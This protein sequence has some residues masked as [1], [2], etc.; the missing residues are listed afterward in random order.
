MIHRDIKPENILI[1]EEDFKAKLCDL[2][3]A[4]SGDDFDSAGRG[5]GTPNYM[6]PEQIRGKN[7]DIR[8]DIYS[9]G[10]TFFRVL[11]GRLPFQGNTPAQTMTLHLR[12]ALQFP[13][14]TMSP[15]TRQ[16]ATVISRMM[17]KSASDR[18]ETPR[19]LVSELEEIIE[20]AAGPPA[21]AEQV[22]DEVSV[23]QSAPGEKPSQRVRRRRRRRRR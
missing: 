21:D 6:S 7:L 23:G 16:L 3:L 18:Y 15:L 13:D 11:F 1:T 17:A 22:N 14:D 12:K 20:Q 9:L 8:T 2:G 5:F 4:W 10:V 19:E